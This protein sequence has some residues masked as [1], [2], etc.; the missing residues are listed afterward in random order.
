[1]SLI[2]KMNIPKIVYLI[3]QSDGMYHNS[4]SYTCSQS[5]NENYSIPKLDDSSTA[6]KSFSW[7]ISKEL[8][9]GRSSRLKQVWALGKLVG[10]PHFSMQNFL[11]PLL[12]LNASKP[13]YG[14]LEVP[15]TNCKSLNRWSLSNFCSITIQNHWMTRSES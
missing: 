9:G 6:S 11:G 5:V 15:V 1:M 14:M 7:S 12:P 8:Y 4:E 2:N 13:S 3:M 10:L